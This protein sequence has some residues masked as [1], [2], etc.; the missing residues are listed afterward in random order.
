ME[1]G[2]RMLRAE[3]GS[4]L[5]FVHRDGVQ[6]EEPP[7]AGCTGGTRAAGPRSASGHTIVSG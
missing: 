3:V 4:A 7:A 1:A 6:E 5:P 2:I